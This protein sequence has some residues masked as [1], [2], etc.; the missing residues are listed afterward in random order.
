LFIQALGGDNAFQT[1][2][3]Y[4]LNTPYSALLRKPIKVRASEAKVYYRDV[5]LVEPGLPGST[6]PQPEFKDY[7]VLEAT[8]NGVDWLP[9][10]PGYDA[11]RK[12]DWQ[13]AFA[14][15]TPGSRS[16]MQD[17]VWEITPVFAPNDTLLFRFRMFS[18]GNVTGWGWALDDLYIQQVPTGLENSTASGVTASPNPTSGEVTISYQLATAARVQVEVLSP[19]GQSVMS[20]DRGVQDAGR[21]ETKLSLRGSAGVYL[22]RVS[23]GGQTAGVLRVVLR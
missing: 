7:V 17:Q 13:T 4:S 8:K 9:I 23:A 22:V 15:N 6:F 19:V 10:S 12:P 3:N 2:H 5:A 11:T 14:A 20:V 16:L 1:P 18:D 21:Q